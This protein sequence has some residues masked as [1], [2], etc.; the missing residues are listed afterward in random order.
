M[1]TCD[2]VETGTSRLGDGVRMVVCGATVRDVNDRVTTGDSALSLSTARMANVWKFVVS[3]YCPGGA[4]GSGGLVAGSV[5]VT[6]WSRVVVHAVSPC[7]G[8]SM[9]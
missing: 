9:E 1:V 7:T 2:S 5:S 6:W 8:G 4:S 3:T